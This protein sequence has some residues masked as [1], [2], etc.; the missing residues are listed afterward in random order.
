VIVVCACSV[1]LRDLNAVGSLFMR[2]EKGELV[3]RW[4]D[5][6]SRNH[7][8]HW[9]NVSQRPLHTPHRQ[10]TPSGNAAAFPP[11]L[12]PSP[13]PPTH[14]GGVMN[15]WCRAGA[16]QLAPRCNPWHARMNSMGT[17]R[18]APSYPP[19]AR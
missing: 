16:A 15:V 12:P 3:E 9:I 18:V 10:P 14:H 4:W 11:S 6:H 2:S 8:W 5:A 13:P 19:R 7:G 1:A 17:R